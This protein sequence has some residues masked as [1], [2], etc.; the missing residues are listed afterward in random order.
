[1]KEYTREFSCLH[2]NKDT[3]FVFLE[4]ERGDRYQPGW[5][6]CWVC[7]ECDEYDAYTIELWELDHD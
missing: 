6:S 2:C 3:E 7:T 1:M 4:G 5:E